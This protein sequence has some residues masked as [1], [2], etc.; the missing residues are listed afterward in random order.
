MGEDHVFVDGA[1]VDDAAGLFGGDEA[2]DEGLREEECA[3]EVDVEDGVV[4]S[5]GDLPEGRFDLD[6]GVV[7]ED[8]GAAELSIGFIDE[9]L[10]VGEDG[11][12]G[13]DGDGFAASGFAFGFGIGGLIGVIT[14]VDDYG[15]ALAGETDGDGLAYSGAGT[16]DDGYFVL[17][18][19]AWGSSRCHCDD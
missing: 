8:V 4:G 1:D 10:G 5:F 15:C 17:Q 12:V 18:R 9:A 2:F 3:L 6:A 13:L 7:D 14:V 16:G 11:D 19:S